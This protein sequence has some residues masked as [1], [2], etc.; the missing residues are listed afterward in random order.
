M[1][2]ASK[3]VINLAKNMREIRVH[4]CQTSSSSAGVRKFIESRYV[5]LK[6]SNPGFP[7]LVRECSC[8][9]PKITARYGFGK[10]VSVRV[11]DVSAEEVH[12]VVEKLSLA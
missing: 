12:D 5:D 6:M 10:E 7:I 4:L 9:E 2:M 3:S 8:V 11:S 1:N